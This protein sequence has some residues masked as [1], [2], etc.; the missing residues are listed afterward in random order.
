MGLALCL[1]ARVA[2]AQ[3]GLPPL[4]ILVMSATLS[5]ALRLRL[6]ALLGGAAIVTSEGRAF[7]VDV[8]HVSPER[9]L[10]RA[11]KG[12]EKKTAFDQ[13][14][15][16]AVANALAETTGDVL[17]FLPGEREIYR[18]AKV[19][20]KLA[21][22]QRALLRARIN[23]K[24]SRGFGAVPVARE[25]KPVDVFPLYGSLDSEAQDRAIGPPE[26]GRRRVVLATNI[27]EASVTVPNVTA[28]VDAGLR[29][30]SRFNPALNMSSLETV[31]ISSASAEQRAGRAGR[32]K[33]G[34][35]YR[36]WGASQKLV[37]ADAPPILQVDVCDSVLALAACGIPPCDVASLPWLD[38]PPRAM[39]DQAVAV[40]KALQA[41]S[42]DG[43]LTD[44]GRE[45]AGLPLHPRL[46]HMVLRCG[47]EDE[48]PSES[49]G[50]SDVAELCAVLSEER[51]LLRGRQTTGSKTTQNI[52]ID[53]RLYALRTG[54]LPVAAAHKFQV[55]A[56][57]R[58]H[59]LRVADDLRRV[60]PRGLGT[61]IVTQVGKFIAVAFPERVARKKSGGT[62]VLRNGSFCTVED[63]S[64]REAPFLVIAQLHQ[65]NG[66]PA[67]ATLAAPLP[68]SV[69]ASMS[70][71]SAVL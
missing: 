60:L 15:G 34:L 59:F 31:V 67:T 38:V 19:V 29:R 11:A 49:D 1:R 69:A 45:L 12:M 44:H 4:R 25:V 63:P 40:L 41:L 7:S 14:F 55:V 2:R 10:H 33:D 16:K 8:R 21:P 3:R 71:A 22:S 62:F 58:R 39:I 54:Q 61:R 46:G 6:A 52:N 17:C 70:L 53:L 36:L 35:C 26:P 65:S 24:R 13:V 42:S 57:Q 9:Y 37:E 56:A 30:C 51:D 64:M 32:L 27:A 47:E 50:T 20:E 48:S 5:D 68:S 66:A 28:V 23:P 43:E 18:L